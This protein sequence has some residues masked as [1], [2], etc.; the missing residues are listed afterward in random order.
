MSYSISPTHL[1]ESLVRAHQHWQERNRPNSDSESVRKAF[2]VA[3]SRE[4]G[5][6]GAAI[7]REVADRLGWPV[8]DH[9]L[10][11]RIADDMGV[12]RTL[13]ES[14]DERQV[15]L[16]RECVA[17]LMS[18]P[19]VTEGAYF[20]QLVETLLALGA[21]GECVIVGR[22]ATVVLPLATTL[23]VRVM[24][25]LEHRIEAV[26]REH[27]IS[28]K[29]ATTQVESKDRERNRFITS[30]FQIDPK[31]SANYDLVLNAARFSIAECADFIIAGLDR[32][33]AHPKSSCT[34]HALEATAGV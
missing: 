34:T 9:E 29:A 28:V 32:I 23:R 3:V 11:Q 27:S 21:H 5:T 14:V 17:S 20:R 10:L 4:T 2:T 26:Q 1:T 6:Y 22:G 7:A 24:A 30:H 25:P 19:G 18:V 33:R 8:Y 16:V 15:G 31:D 13:L 12:R